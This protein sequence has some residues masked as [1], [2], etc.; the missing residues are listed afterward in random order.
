ML[1]MAWGKFVNQ[2]DRHTMEGFSVLLVA[3]TTYSLRE[4]VYTCERG[5]CSAVRVHGRE[6]VSDICSYGVVGD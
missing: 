4:P 1:S 2:K 5:E 3:S 6:S